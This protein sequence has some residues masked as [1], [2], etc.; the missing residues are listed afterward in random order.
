MDA[1][2]VIAESVE[3][4]HR[5]DAERFRKLAAVVVGIIGMLLAI[6]SLG[7]EYYMKETINSNILSS[8]TYNFYQARN[9][10]QTGFA[11]AADNL[12]EML[13]SQPAMPDA[14]R[15]AIAK[16]I[17]DYRKTVQR[18]ESDPVAGNGKAELLAKAKA[19]EAQ[20]DE[21]QMRD[22]NF[23]FARAFYEI[24]VV[25][26]SVGIVAASPPLLGLAGL[27][28]ALATVLSVNGFF[29]FADLPLH[30]L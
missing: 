27:L 26:A 3:E 22:L 28:A 12:E 29:P 8:D 14:S 18:Y 24:A 21:A 11:L 6:A 25:L 5:P 2:E 10:R 1:H 30:V 17:A 16:K 13:A 19:Y 4:K 23:D 15:A 20:R 9:I 7:G